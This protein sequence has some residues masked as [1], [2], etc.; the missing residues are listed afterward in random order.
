MTAD[1]L[2]HL[3]GLVNRKLSGREKQKVWDAVPAMFKLKNV[4][5]LYRDF[6]AWLNRKDMLVAYHVEGL[7]Y[8][9]VF[10][11]IYCK[12]RLEGTS[13]YDRGK[14]PVGRRDAGLHSNHYA[15]LSRVFLCRKTILGD[16]SQTVQSLQ[17]FVCQHY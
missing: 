8:S 17:R 13:S 1:I 10:P 12:I 11:L 15:V 4:F 3:R 7:E 5:D 16:I 6:Y 14:A 2:Q 9:D